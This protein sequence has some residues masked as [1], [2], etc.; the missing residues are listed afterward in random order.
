MLCF[1][2]KAVL[3]FAKRDFN[4]GCPLAVDIRSA[5]SESVLKSCNN[6]NL[7]RHREIEYF[8]PHI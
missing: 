8:Y 5:F 6:K 3:C 4:A 2:I 7:K 1:A